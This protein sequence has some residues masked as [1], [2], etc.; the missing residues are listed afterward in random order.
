MSISFLDASAAL[1]TAVTELPAGNRDKGGS[2]TPDPAVREVMENLKPGTWA[3]VALATIE[4]ASQSDPAY[5]EVTS[6]RS[7]LQSFADSLAKNTYTIRARTQ[8]DPDL[9]KVCRL[10]VG[11][12]V[13]DEVTAVESE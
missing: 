9:G 10:Y 11:K 4:R 6:I 7:K 3:Q 5:R 12:L 13:A 2:F 1:A 8:N